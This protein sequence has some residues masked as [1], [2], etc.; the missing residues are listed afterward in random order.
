[1]PATNDTIN[2]PA[3]A[4]YD[5]AWALFIF[6]ALVVVLTAFKK[7]APLGFTLAGIL[8]FVWLLRWMQQRKTS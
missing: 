8:I 3:A 7:T 4:P 6:L 5:F 2:M 1:M